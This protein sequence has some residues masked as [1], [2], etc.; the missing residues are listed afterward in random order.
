MARVRRLG[1]DEWLAYRDLRLQ[2]LSDSPD[3]FRST[4]ERE[5][6]RPDSEWIARVTSGA[7]S[8][9]DRPLVAT[10]GSELVGIGWGKVLESE[11]GTVHV[12]QMWVA[13]E[14]R[15]RG[16]GAEL[17]N[18]I[19]AWARDVKADRVVLGVT[20]GN[21]S[22]WRLYI[23]AGFQASGEPEPLRAGSSLFSQR[24]ILKL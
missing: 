4:F 22:A 20:C 1:S 18:A 19:V 13:P 12:F 9:H 11:P 14:S 7:T 15:G 5:S 17:L 6:S 10:E 24:M 8:P 2:A 23:R 21:S 16:I 3:A